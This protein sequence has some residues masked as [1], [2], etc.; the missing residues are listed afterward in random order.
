[1]FVLIIIVIVQ[2]IFLKKYRPY[3]M[4]NTRPELF[5]R[6]YIQYL[7]KH[8]Q[9]FAKKFEKPANDG[10]EIAIKTRQNM[11]ARL[12]WLV[13]ERDFTTTTNPD[14]RYWEDINSRIQDMLAHW[15][16]IEFIKEPPDIE[17]ITLAI[18]GAPEDFDYE[19]TDIDQAVK[20]QITALKKKVFAMSGYESMYKELEMAYKT[21]EASYEELVRSMRDLKVE[22]SEAEKLKQIIAE[23][24]ENEKN[25]TAMMSEIENSKERLN[26]ELNQ[27][28]GA[29]EALESDSSSP[30]ILKTSK[31][32]D[33]QEMLEILNQ[34]EAILAEFRKT[35]KTL[36]MKPS[37]QQKV[38]DHT[39][40]ME[41]S[42][43]E[44]NHS[45][46]MLELE[47]ERLAEEVQQ[48]Q[49]EVENT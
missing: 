5:L 49:A 21:Q 19:K 36:N 24:E 25:L 31:N 14:I 20:D 10:D 38:D 2:G 11:T 17:V 44:I 27:L 6:K 42:H 1:M 34:Q 37:Q 15:K 16:E 23:Q 32:P 26:E 30:N 46:Q 35:L 45:M 13:L 9:K 43:K 12:N 47:R 33:A 41:K 48:M 28:E 18:D 22:A 39:D 7:I 8:T 3:Y 4:A 29:L 40:K